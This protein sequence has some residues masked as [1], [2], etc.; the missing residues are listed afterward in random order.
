MDLLHSEHGDCSIPFGY[1]LPANQNYFQ[2]TVPRSFCF[3]SPVNKHYVVANKLYFSSLR[4]VPGFFNIAATSL[5]QDSLD[6]ENVTKSYPITLDFKI[7]NV[8]LLNDNER[9]KLLKPTSTTTGTPESLAREF[10]KVIGQLKRDW[11]KELPFFCDWVPWSSETQ[12]V[13]DNVDAFIDNLNSGT[14]TGID[15]YDKYLKSLT[16]FQRPMSILNFSSISHEFK[17]AKVNKFKFPELN[18]INARIRLFIAPYSALSA[19]NVMIFKS[20]GFDDTQYETSESQVILSNLNS[21]KWKSITAK[22]PSFFQ[23][24]ID[25]EIQPQ[26]YFNIIY[27]LDHNSNTHNFVENI[28]LTKKELVEKTPVVTKMNQVITNFSD[29]LN[30]RLFFNSQTKIFVFPPLNSSIH[31]MK[32]NM[33]K[34]IASNLGYG[35]VQ[36]ITNQSKKV[37]IDSKL[38]FE[39]QALLLSMNTGLIYVSADYSGLSQIGHTQEAFLGEL[40]PSNKGYLDLVK[41]SQ[42]EIVDYFTVSENQS[43]SAFITLTFKMKTF[44]KKGYIKDFAWTNDAKVFGNLRSS[45]ISI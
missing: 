2:V 9:P 23:K 26:T 7:Y 1:N 12:Q 3:Y 20:L 21:D 17:F 5:K 11:N 30:V 25:N 34:L 37:A 27:A 32:I 24:L 18:N 33:P 36:Y 16:K 40:E 4:I 31:L 45:S 41:T 15:W 38:S 44:N 14:I 10:N 22:Y 19:S 28:I 6:E 29:K 8:S 43:G 35:T 13:I 39:K 42:H